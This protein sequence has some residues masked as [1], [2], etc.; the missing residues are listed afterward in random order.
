M[1][2]L[3]HNSWFDLKVRVGGLCLYS[4]D[5]NRQRILLEIKIGVI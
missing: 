4:R 5:F 3:L 2:T 1:P